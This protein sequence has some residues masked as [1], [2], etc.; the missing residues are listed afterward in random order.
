MSSI[1]SRLFLYFHYNTVL[2]DSVL[3]FSFQ[4]SACPFLMMSLR[5]LH[6]LQ[7]SRGGGGGAGRE[8]VL[9]SLQCGGSASWNYN[10]SW[11]FNHSGAPQITKR[12]PLIS[13]WKCINNSKKNLVKNGLMIL[14]CKRISYACT[15]LVMGNVSRREAVS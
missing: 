1:N 14:S 6:T 15:L 7:P 11:V 4:S 5:S 8:G 13:C 10:F 12:G 9:S 2:C 3:L